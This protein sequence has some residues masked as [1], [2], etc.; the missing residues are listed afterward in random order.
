MCIRDR[1]EANLLYENDFK[2]SAATV[3]DVLA[4]YHPH[5]DASVYDAMVRLAQDFSLRSVSYTH[6][7]VYKRQVLTTVLLTQSVLNSTF[8]TAEPMQC[9]FLT[10][11][12]TTQE[13]TNIQEV[14]ATILSA[15]KSMST[16]LNFLV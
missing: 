7:D 1:Y 5:G 9:Y 8:R 12:N 2:K 15:L 16:L 11:S 3:C 13:L 4:K 6:L 14:K 10:L